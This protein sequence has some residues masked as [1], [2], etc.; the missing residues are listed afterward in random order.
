MSSTNRSKAREAH[1]YDKY[2]TPTDQ[3]CL[4]LREFSSVVSLDWN[5]AIILDPCAGGD[6]NNPPAYPAAI[7]K[8]FPGELYITSLDIREDS[9]CMFPGTNFLELK[10]NLEA[11]ITISNPPFN[12]ALDFIKHAM[13]VTV[14]GGWVIMLLRLNFLESV[15]RKEFFDQYMPKY[16]FVHH[17]RMSFTDDG[18]TDSVAYAHFC[19]KVGDYPEFSQ[20]K[21]I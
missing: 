2:F 20:T 19:W 1:T 5:D 11:D 12:C 18:A 17:R 13:S 8:V 10:E 21:I 6:A 3:I 4:F 9:P 7:E 16:I 15:T 14:Q